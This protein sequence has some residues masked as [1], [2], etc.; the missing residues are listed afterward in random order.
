MTTG[1]DRRPA[2][3]LD[4][5]PGQN[6]APD[7]DQGRNPAPDRGPGPNLRPGP[8]LLPDRR[9]ALGLGRDRDPSLDQGHPLGQDPVL[10]LDRL[11]ARN[12]GPV[13]AP[14]PRQDPDQDRGRDQSRD[15]TKFK[16]KLI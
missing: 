3:D 4:R 1:R 9:R 11:R 13:Q 6:Q 12:P 16:A 15:R 8:A 14:A 7:Q 2:Q 10:P 5:G